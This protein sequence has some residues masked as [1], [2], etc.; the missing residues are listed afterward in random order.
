MRSR[1]SRASPTKS[2]TVSIPGSRCTPFDSPFE[3]INSAAGSL[4]RSAPMATMM[5]VNLG[6]GRHRMGNRRW[7][8]PR[9]SSANA[10]AT[11]CARLPWRTAMPP[12][13]SAGRARLDRRAASTVLQTRAG[14]NSNA[15]HL[16]GLFISKDRIEFRYRAIN[17]S[18]RAKLSDR[19][20]FALLFLPVLYVLYLSMPEPVDDVLVSPLGCQFT[21]IR[22]LRGREHSFTGGCERYCTLEVTPVQMLDG[23]CI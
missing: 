10:A 6:T 15:D 7:S 4:W 11:P 19:N 14:A 13:V 23:R 5:A 3:E 20:G 16:R 22:L 8:A 2:R 9:T 21:K 18:N 17:H 1:V 12:E